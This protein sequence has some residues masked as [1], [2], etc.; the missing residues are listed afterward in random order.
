MSDLKISGTI[1]K[2]L[3]VEKG[4]SGAGKDWQKVSFV[5]LPP[6][7][8]AKDICFQI[9]GEDKVNNFL[10]YN[11]IGAMVDVSFNVSSREY[12]GKYFHNLDAWRVF[13][14]DAASQEQPEEEVDLPF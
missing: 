6:D 11:K 14:S 3:E 1:T 7:Q 9:F 12:N 8:Y 10:K 5:I 4:V 2:I 13:K